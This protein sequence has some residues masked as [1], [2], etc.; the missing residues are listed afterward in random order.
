[1]Q[2]SVSGSPTFFMPQLGTSAAAGSP[3]T[4]P[5]SLHP[6]FSVGHESL[7]CQIQAEVQK[8]LAHITNQM[9]GQLQ[10][11]LE[12]GVQEIVSKISL[13]ETKCNEFQERSAEHMQML[14]D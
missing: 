1:M 13:V 14:E 3:Q 8:Q 10:A 4:Y 9:L 7:A 11:Q 12:G 5:Y 6:G 2:Y